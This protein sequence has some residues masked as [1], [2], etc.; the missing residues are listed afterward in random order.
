MILA[1]ATLVT[2]LGLLVVSLATANVLAAGLA[3]LLAASAVWVMLLIGQS[4]L[5][6]QELVYNLLDGEEKPDE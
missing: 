4:R 6:F 1:L 3:L 5:L 2:A